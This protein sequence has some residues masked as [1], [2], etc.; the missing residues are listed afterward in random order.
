MY[1]KTIK[2][3]FEIVSIKGNI[4]EDVILFDSIEILFKIEEVLFLV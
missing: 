2:N 3:T 4:I 1:I